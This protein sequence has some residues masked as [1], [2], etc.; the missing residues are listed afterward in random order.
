MS[1]ETIPVFTLDGG[2][3]TG[4]GA[5]CHA[6]AAKLGFHSLDS[7]V[8]YRTLGLVCKWNNITSVQNMIDAAS[9]LDIKTQEEEVFLSNQNITKEVRSL[10]GGTLAR[11]IGKI[12][13][14][15]AALRVFQLNQRMFPG[16]VTDGRDQG[17]V[18]EGENVFRYF[19]T[20]DPQV[21]AVRRCF[22]LKRLGMAVDH[23]M[24]IAEILKRNEEDR[25][26]KVDPLVPHAE[27]L[28]IDT[29][30]KSI[31]EVTQIILDH[32]G[33]ETQTA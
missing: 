10:E 11:E 14:V 15:R 8:L 12:P 22:Q 9:Q 1:L 28:T 4:K 3:A 21:A 32:S 16:L 7:G 27:A 6:L 31:T 24:V 19:L 25:T 5:V 29:T 2:V 23:D 30:G 17:F 13:E 20:V 18:F 33:F 26:R